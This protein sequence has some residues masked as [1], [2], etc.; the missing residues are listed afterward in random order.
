MAYKIFKDKL[1]NKDYYIYF[2]FNYL[3]IAKVSFELRSL[4]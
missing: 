3:K 1:T 2:Y 4:Y